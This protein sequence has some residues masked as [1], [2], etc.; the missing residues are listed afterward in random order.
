MTSDITTGSLV[1]GEPVPRPALD[2]FWAD[3]L[4]RLRRYAA[5]LLAQMRIP[6]GRLDVDDVVQSVYETLLINWET[7][8]NPV[9]YARS[10]V[11]AV[12]FEQLRDEKRYGTSPALLQGG[13]AELPDDALSAED[14][15]IER[16]GRRKHQATLKNTPKTSRAR[17]KDQP[18]SAAAAGPSTAAAAPAPYPGRLQSHSSSLHDELPRRVPGMHIDVAGRF[19]LGEQE[20]RAREARLQRD[21]E[22]KAEE[23]QRR[24]LM[25]V[26]SGGAT[27]FHGRAPAGAAGNRE[28]LNTAE[29]A[30]YVND[31]RPGRL[32][33]SDE[34]ERRIRHRLEQ[35]AVHRAAAAPRP[36]RPVLHPQNDSDITTAM[37]GD[38]APPP[39]VHRQ[40][41]VVRQWKW[42]S[43]PPLPVTLSLITLL[44]AIITGSIS[45]ALDHYAGWEVISALTENP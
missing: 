6:D 45:I 40:Q 36:R 44:V 29:I 25:R 3:Y 2:D 18:G 14:A 38:Q 21:A 31:A 43:T 11:K 28:A 39:R 5:H 10:Q 15:L 26:I 24:E 17:K 35:Q 1:A 34:R 30:R 7:V 42:T 23:A 32:Y 41:Q 20:V 9:G 27:R 22:R 33:S 19:F 12:V 37:P 13:G 4:P 16:E 8:G